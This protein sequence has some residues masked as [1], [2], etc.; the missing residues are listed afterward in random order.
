[1]AGAAPALQFLPVLGK[2]FPTASPR[3]PFWKK[4]S[5][6]IHFGYLL[7]SGMA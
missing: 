1:M 2:N 6:S 5:T 4:V 3:V 7:P